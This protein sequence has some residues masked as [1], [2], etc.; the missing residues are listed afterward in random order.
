MLKKT[1][2]ASAAYLVK[3]FDGDG[4]PRLIYTNACQ[5]SEWLIG[6][7][8]AEGVGVIW[9]LWKEKEDGVIWDSYNVFN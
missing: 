3:K 6:K 8:L 2:K 7:S 9:D 4:G 1:T 5:G